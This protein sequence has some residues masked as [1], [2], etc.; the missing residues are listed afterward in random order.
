MLERFKT[1]WVHQTDD[2]RWYR[3]A[4]ILVEHRQP[5]IACYIAGRLREI[6]TGLIC[7]IRGHDLVDE[8][9]AGPDSGCV[10]Y[11]CKRC[12]WGWCKVLY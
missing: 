11:H 5:T 9:S 10:A 4:S 3:G 6:Y 7:K 12:G 1:W 8:S 2:W